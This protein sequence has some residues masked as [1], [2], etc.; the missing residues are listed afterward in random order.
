MTVRSPA[1][2]TLQ[3]HVPNTP[4]SIPILPDR[5]LVL[6]RDPACDVVFTDATVSRR[7]CELFMRDEQVWLR[8]LSGKNAT[9]VNGRIVMGEVALAAGDVLRLPVVEVRVVAGDGA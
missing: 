8:H 4:T 6:G 5:P 9:Y 7:H 1:A 3:L 2:L